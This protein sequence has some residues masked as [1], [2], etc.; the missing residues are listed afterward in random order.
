MSHENHENG[1]AVPAIPL[2]KLEYQNPNRVEGSGTY[3]REG[4]SLRVV[5]GAE[6]PSRCVKC[7]SS[8]EVEMRKRTLYWYP[9]WTFLLIF[10]NILIFAVVA[11]CVR[12]KVSLTYG[13]CARHRMLRTWGM[14]GGFGG[15]A[16]GIVLLI[17]AA[18][19]AGANGPETWIYIAALVVIVGAIAAGL[20]MAHIF[21][22]EVIRNGSAWLRGVS[23]DFLETL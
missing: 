21:R 8:V 11:M 10:L 3:W 13:L 22:V 16:L 20:I 12:R 14:L 4:R 2:A 6:L 7:N 5:D 23:K 19:Y 17:L 15:V 1:Q 9:Q 18:N